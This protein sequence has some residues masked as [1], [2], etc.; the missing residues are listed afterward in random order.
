MSIIGSVLGRFSELT[1]ST[2]DEKHYTLKTGPVSRLA[3]SIIGLP[4]LGFRGRAA[5]ILKEATK[6][7]RAESRILD[8]GCGY[9]I[10][11]LTLADRGRRHIDAVDLTPQ[12]IAALERMKAERPEL[13]SGI[14]L[15]IGSITALP[16]DSD[17]YD[18]TIC[19]EVIEHVP[20]DARGAS[21]LLRVTR[22]GGRLIISVPYASRYNGRIYK[23]FGHERPGYT[24]D[25]LRDLFGQDKVKVLNAHYYEYSLGTRLF[26]GFNRLTSKPLMGILF[27]PFYALYK[28][29]S[30]LKI[31]EPNGIVV[32]MEKASG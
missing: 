25:S 2:A 30:L 22:P 5:I 28:L 14:S 26:N 19:S 16:Y 4:H 29:D 7:T 24:K 27:Y 31:G 3:I 15:K 18:L 20:D 11:S 21:E 32:I 23:R 10:Y 9:G 17:C 13:M 6:A 1:L 8:A 12:R